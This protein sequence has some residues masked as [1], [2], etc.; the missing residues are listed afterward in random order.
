[1]RKTAA[2]EKGSREGGVTFSKRQQQPLGSKKKKGKDSSTV[3][4]QLELKMVDSWR[5][6]E[7]ALLK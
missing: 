5:E 1:M 4:G 6:R 2:N 3:G 7:R